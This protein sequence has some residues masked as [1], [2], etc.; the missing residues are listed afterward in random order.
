MTGNIKAKQK[1][2]CG[3]KFEDNSSQ[4]SSPSAQNTDPVFARLYTRL[5]ANSSDIEKFRGGFNKTQSFPKTQSTHAPTSFNNLITDWI[6]PSAEY[7]KLVTSRTGLYRITA[8]EVGVTNWRSAEVRMFNK[9]IEVPIWIDSTTDGRINAI[10]YYGEMLHGNPG[11]FY[12]WDT[13]KNPYWLTNTRKFSTA[14]KRFQDKV[15]SGTP[16]STITEG[17]IILHH[18]RD[19]FYSGGD[20]EAGDIQTLHRFEWVPGERF[21][22]QFLPNKVNDKEIFDVFDTFMI[23]SLPADLTGKT[24]Q[25][26]TLVK[27]ISKANGSTVIHKATVRV[28]G[29]SFVISFSEYQELVSNFSIPLSALHVGANSF[30]I[31]FRQG[32]DSPDKWYFDYYTLS[33]SGPLGASTD[34]A[35]ARGQWA[36]S[37]SPSSN[38]FN[39][40]L[41]AQAES[42]SLYDLTNGVKL[43]GNG[44]IFK[45]EGSNS[46]NY[47]AATS[48]SFLHPDSI[49]N[50]TGQFAEILDTTKGADYILITHPLF[51]NTAKKLEARRQLAG[52]RTKVLT[53]EAVFDAFNFGSDEPWAIRE[54][55]QYAYEHYAGAPPSFV[56]LLGDGTWDAKYN[57]NNQLQDNGAKTIHQSFVPTYGVPNS[58]YVFTT[59]GVTGSIDSESFRMVIARIPV[60]SADEA[61]SY[62][63][64][65]I[66]YETGQPAAW[67]KN[68]LF[69]AGGDPGGQAGKLADYE[70]LFVGLPP[71]QT[72]Q[73]GGL[74]NPPISIRPTFLVRHDF[75]SP[76]DITQIPAIQSSFKEGQSLVYFFGHGAPNITDVQFPDVGT[77]R[78]KGAYPLFISVSCRTGAFAEPNIISMNESFIR[79]PEAGAILAFGTT[80]Y[81]DVE[82]DFNMSARAFLSMRSD[83][84]AFRMPR[85]GPHRINLPMILTTSK[86]I[87]SVLQPSTD[88]FMRHNSLY[89]YAI[90][91]DAALGFALRPQPEFSI[92]ASDIVLLGKD[93]VPRTIFSL[94]DSEITVKTTLHNFGYGLTEPVHVRITDN[95]PG[96]RQ[97]V[98]I[99]TITTFELLA[100]TGAV[101]TLDTFAVGSNS[102]EVFIDHDNQFAETDENDNSATVNFLVNG[103]SAAPFYPPEGSKYFCDLGTDSVR[104]ILLLPPDKGAVANIAIEFDTT[105]AFNSSVLKTFSGLQGSGVFFQRSF[106]RSELPDPT[107]KVLWWRSKSNLSNGNPSDWQIHSFSISAPKPPGARSEFSYSTADQLL[108]TIQ[109]GLQ[110]DKADGALFIPQHDT[111]SY[112]VDARGFLDQNVVNQ[113]PIGQL[114]FNGNVAFQTTYES[115]GAFIPLWIL[116]LTAD[117]SSLDSVIAFKTTAT[118][119]EFIAAVNGIPDGRR[120]FVLTNFDPSQLFWLGS[121]GARDAMRS[122]GS[123]NGFDS[124]GF[125]KSYALIGRK[126]M[127]SGQAIEAFSPAGSSGVTLTDRTVTLGK[128]GF[129]RTPFTAIADSYGMLRWEPQSINSHSNIILSVLGERRKGGSIDTVLVVD[130]ST[131]NSA[132]LSSVPAA[133]YDR[134]LVKMNFHRD[135]SSAIS[136]RLKLVELEYDP[137]PE[138]STSDSLI[139]V[140][141]SVV[142]EGTAVSVNYTVENVTCID[143]KNVLVQLVQN[144]HGNSSIIATDTIIAFVGH[145]RS[146]FTHS[147]PTTGFDGLVRLSA[148][149]NPGNV[150]SEQLSFNNT[151]NAS[152]IVVHD[153]TK[154]KLDLLFDGNHIAS[155][156]YV[157]SRVTIEV[158]LADNSPLR[159]ADSNSITGTLQAL[160]GSAS[161]QIFSGS[162]I[163]ANFTTR[164]VTQPSGAVQAYLDITPDSA[165]KPGRYLFTAMANDATGN[166]ADTLSEEFVVSATNGFEH[167]MNYPNP[168]KENT[169]FTFVLKSASQAEVKIVVYTVAGRKIRTLHLDPATQHAGLNNIEWDGRD[170]MGNDVAN[171]TYL[172][173]AVLNGSNDDGSTASEGLTERAVRSR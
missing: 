11:E 20:G 7:I 25:L 131:A 120:V 126:G 90:L 123:R 169:F 140:S 149:V 73:Y 76:I 77:L 170:E 48:Q 57:L 12:S 91:G 165:L 72:N 65:L 130:A 55:L 98:L 153:S 122:L 29:I 129:A 1:F 54:Y 10:E 95:Q 4:R 162:R 6:D 132:D 59:S 66:E 138:F 166:R 78:N 87:E 101:I 45:D 50:M 117:S 157:S 16:A 24:A 109:S 34:T 42:P 47:V 70:K 144:Y 137:S 89:E 9:G 136:P 74:G 97:I 110:V 22:W 111:I 39:I 58:D 38:Q 19:Y 139:K 8:A 105:S 143:G 18:E 13:D 80:G 99:D 147:L 75:L 21:V 60:E 100:T 51:L 167:V 81:G 152:Y 118:V 151:A 154:P 40:G 107:S 3:I 92:A 158:R 146:S 46:L 108:T 156:E 128:S 31:T 172:Y 142:L 84:S 168:F 36:F 43:I 121:S 53:T 62:L 61:E 52:L 79:V 115:N 15:I 103:Y 171:G 116:E 26:T 161:P 64:K 49:I 63:Q 145:S 94:G 93:S 159:I 141:P 56:T 85:F 148:T 5:A 133:F 96:N 119:D 28:N 134:L 37:L 86:Y 14:P 125:A 83:D 30:Q 127:A 135:S 68:F 102:L 44:N 82:Y 67:N 35:I 114:L 32:T 2:S 104:L 164:F 113:R 17:N 163:T 124:I 155:G 160:F 150:L 41:Q 33:Y 106:S 112:Q 173:R 23:S 69:V 27:G 88:F 71:F